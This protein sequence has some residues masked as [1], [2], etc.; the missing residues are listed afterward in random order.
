MKTSKLSATFKLGA[1]ALVFLVLGYEIALFASQAVRLKASST[2]DRPDTVFVYVPE[3]DSSQKWE[4]RR[5]HTHPKAVIQARSGLGKAESFPFDP[6]TAGEDDLVRLGLSRNQAAS[7]VRYREKG[8]RFRRREDFARSYCVPDSVYRRLEPFIRIPRT[9]INLA[10]SAALDALPG[11]GGYFASR[12][13]EYRERLGGYSY[14]EQLMDIYHFD[15]QKFAALEDL[16]ECSPPEHP[17]RIWSLP[18][19]SLRLHPYIRNYNAARAIVLLR[20]N[21]PRDSLCVELIGKAG[22]LSEEDYLRLSRCVLE[23][24]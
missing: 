12:I 14:P 10:D 18:A 4:E 20:E 17:F 8:G 9:D 3:N 15:E 7:I 1:V 22:I 23:E 16:V 5:N 21:T 6:N 24:P 13:V 19:D 2:L 11:I